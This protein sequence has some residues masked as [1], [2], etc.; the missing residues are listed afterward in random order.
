[1]IS[2]LTRITSSFEKATTVQCVKLHIKPVALDFGA[3]PEQMHQGFFSLYRKHRQGNPQIL[4]DKTCIILFNA[5]F[6]QMFPRRCITNDE[7]LFYRQTQS[8]FVTFDRGQY[9]FIQ[10]KVESRLDYFLVSEL[11]GLE[12]VGADTVPGYCYDH[13]LVC[14]G[15]KSG[16]C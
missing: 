7:F 8:S 6:V 16:I 14:I 11:L 4:A 10:Q 5:S 2:L 12:I 15:F 3:V 9:A 1:M 13:S